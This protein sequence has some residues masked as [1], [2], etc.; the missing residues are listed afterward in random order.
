M[1]RDSRSGRR[2]GGGP[3]WVKSPLALVRYP[4]IVASVLVGAALLSLVAVSYPLYLS[5]SEGTVLA[6]RIAEGTISPYGAGVFYGVSS[7]QFDE[8]APGDDALL[9][10]RLDEEFSR[11]AAEG[12][13]LGRPVRYVMGAA[14]LVSHPGEHR[15]PSNELGGLVFGGTDAAQNVDIIWGS[16]GG[17]ALVPD[18]IA[19]EL[20][21][22]AGD[23]I[24]LFGASR[25]VTVRVGGAYKSFYALPRQGYWS[26]WSEQVYRCLNCP[27]PLQPII[28][29]YGEAIDLSRGVGNQYVDLGWV[30]PVTRL[31][32]SLDEARAVETYTTSVIRRAKD[33]ET[34]LGRL[35]ACCGITWP[36]GFRH[37]QRQTEF[38]SAMPLVMRE[39]ERRTAS[40]EG[41]LGLLRLAGL[42]VAAAVVAAAAVFAIAGRRTEAALLNARGW[43]PLAFAV[44]AAL[45]AFI[46]AAFGVAIGLGLAS[47]L[48]VS[49]GPDGPTAGSAISA[50]FASAALAFVA[51]LL[52]LAVVSAISFVRAF[53]RRTL[54]HRLAGVPWE[55]LAIGGGLWVLDRLRSGG[56]LIEDARLDLRRPSASLLVFPVLFVAGFATLGARAF[57]QTLKRNGS[58]VSS[59]AGYLSVHRLTS[60]PR[61][62][63]VLVGATAL[64]LGVA[65][66]AQTMVGSL[67]STVDAKARVFVGSDVAVWV[68]HT[69]PDQ[70]RFPLPITRATRLKYA[71]SLIPGQIPFDMVGIDAETVVGAAFWDEEF[72]DEP[73]D[74]LV[75]RLRSTRGA[76][77]V[78]LIQGEAK[79]TAIET[80]QVQLPIRVIG[81]AEAFPGVASDDPAVVVDVEALDARLGSEPSPL[82]STNARTEYWIKG[83]TEEALASVAELEAFPLGT[84]TAD[85]VKDIPFVA[86]AIDTFVVLNLLGLAAASLVIGVIL[87][88]LQA[89]QRART[90]SHIL[91][92]RM[93][94]RRIEATASLVIELGTILIVAF[95]LGGSLGIAAGA[96]VASLLDPL[97]TIPPP[98]L[99]T[100]PVTTAAWTFVALLV[101]AAVGGWFV[102]WR[103]DRVH[104]GELLRVAE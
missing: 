101:I 28:V 98:P 72:A 6:S 51:A 91:S 84:V 40:V 62:T 24:E 59:R 76:L 21:L 81:R 8:T 39:V 20:E 43:S 4:G 50:S 71:G 68:D 2:S 55:L 33:P 36:R 32:L 92:L 26:P 53:E 11:L 5:R 34:E 57:V 63:V 86:A 64:C 103:A 78:L 79:P 61:L 38:R 77:P 35:F 97:Q 44:K 89:R 18:L 75:G 90:V 45:E 56:A 1:T 16:P 93:G 60:N 104:L 83:D 54:S 70:E 47:W 29:G 95:G 102:R 13:H 25:K 67:R 48:I 100:S 17:G 58:R 14:V 65:L 85:F 23:P 7:V 3:I 12:P 31:P 73:L 69:A 88:Y 94:M 66:N 42:A 30:A 74:V 46:P 9:R 19:E 49:F 99:F 96:L 87:V 22:R 80:A 10:E 82:G 41:P 37:A 27:V 52:I 15:S